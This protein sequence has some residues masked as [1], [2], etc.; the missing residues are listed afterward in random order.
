MFRRIRKSCPTQIYSVG[1]WH[2][3]IDAPMPRTIDVGTLAEPA[4]CAERQSLRLI[5]GL[6]SICKCKESKT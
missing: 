4:R 5:A 2:A 1:R 3:E 6:S